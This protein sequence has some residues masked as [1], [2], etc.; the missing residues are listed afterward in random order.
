M[1]FSRPLFAP[2]TA[3][4]FLAFFAALAAWP[5]AQAPQCSANA[6]NVANLRLNGQAEAVGDVVVTC[7]GGTPTAT[8]Q[9]VPGFNFTVTDFA[10]VPITS[11]LLTSNWSEALLLVDETPAASQLACTGTC[12]IQGTGTGSGTYSGVQGRPNIFQAQQSNANVLT[13]TNVPFDPP[14]VN[15]GVRIFRFTNVRVNASSLNVQAQ[16]TL[17]LTIIG[18]TSLAVNPSQ[19]VVATAFTPLNVTLKGVQTGANGLAQFALSF[20][21]SYA[22]SFKTRTTATDSGISPP[23]ANQSTP[24]QFLP[25]SETHFYNSALPFAEGRGNLG[26]AGLADNGTRLGLVTVPGNSGRESL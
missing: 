20:T 3:A 21:E 16:V 26:T 24:N 10:S 17:S 23:P 1:T 12:S 4:A 19:A 14:G 9:I 7:T 22:S 6:A 8:G 18:T 11:R 2:R 5:K 25:S 13:F 15:G